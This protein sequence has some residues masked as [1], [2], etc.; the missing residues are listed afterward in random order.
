MSSNRSPVKN[1]EIL[2]SLLA[3]FVASALFAWWVVAQVNRE[4]RANLLQQTRLVVQAMDVDHIKDLI[5]T[6]ADV[7]SSYYQRLKEQLAATRSVNP[8]CRFVYLMGRKADGAVFFFVDSERAGTKD[9]SPPGQVYEEVPAGYQRVFDTKTPDVVGP[10][11]DRW[12]VWVSAL[13]PITDQTSGAVVGVLGMDINAGSWRWDIAMRTVLPGGLMLMLLLMAFMYI[14]LHRTHAGTRAQ[15]AALRESEMKFRTLFDSAYDAVLLIKDYV[16]F[17]CNQKT[18]NMFGCAKE[19]IIGWSPTDLSPETQLDGLLSSGKA[20]EKMNMAME[21]APQFFEWKHRRMDGALF[22]A[23]VR[24]N[25]IEIADVTYLQAVVR[26]VTERKQIERALQESEARW[27]FALEGA[28]DGVWDWDA[29][30]NRVF[31]STR[32]KAMLGYAEQEIGDTL[33]EWD[34]RVHPDDKAG[35]Y[36]DLERHFRHE[37]ACYQNEHRV[38]CKDGSYKWILD[39][40]KVIEWTEDGKPRRVIGTHT[41]INERKQIEGALQ[42]SEEKYRILVEKA[43]EAIIIVQDDVLIFANRRTSDLLGV[44]VTDLEGKPFTRFI[45]PEDRERVIANYRKRVAGETVHDAYDFRVIGAGGK[46]NWV[47]LSATTIQ[48]KGKPATLNLMSDI[49]DRKQA[50]E[51]RERLILELKEALSQ[52]RTLSGLVPICASCKKIRNDK[53][54]WEQIEVYIRDH[55][56]AEFS[57][58]ICPECAQRLYPELYKKR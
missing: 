8:K 22:D 54:Y 30:T 19:D 25:R 40:G 29:V 4:M 50:E 28:G 57:H 34:R 5:G 41:D 20:V 56:E 37:T 26:D 10:V 31:F 2:L 55:S 12:G 44:P 58:G 52:V 3:I 24:L 51:E 45:W 49:T 33:D 32:W 38:L 16:L 48:W 14:L 39:R 13:V 6:E 53:G 7:N 47:F 17:D 11:T 18:L 46:L 23:E 43:N 35:A 36:A 27:Q 9:Y 1:K 42:E 21:G 15:Q